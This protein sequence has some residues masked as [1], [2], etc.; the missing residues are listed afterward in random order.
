MVTVSWQTGSHEQ[1][2]FP[3]SGRDRKPSCARP[4]PCGGPGRASRA[5][6]FYCIHSCSALPGYVTSGGPA[7]G[8]GLVVRSVHRLCPH[9]AQPVW[10][11]IPWLRRRQ[12]GGVSQVFFF[13]EYELGRTNVL[14]RH[15]WPQRKAE[16]GSERTPR[17]ATATY[18]GLASLLYLR[19]CRLSSHVS[20][21]QRVFLRK[22]GSEE[23]RNRP[24]KLL[25]HF[26]TRYHVPL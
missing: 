16:L 11:G 1:Q 10:T 7:E 24:R 18:A 9:L 8:G 26:L 3:P 15:F 12:S 17:L 22:P 4:S 5:L 20:L 23:N 6:R 13:R 19:K 25:Q 14:K 2:H 21:Q